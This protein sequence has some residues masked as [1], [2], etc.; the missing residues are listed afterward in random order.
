MKKTRFSGVSQRC[1]K[2]CTA[3]PCRKHAFSVYVDLRPASTQYTKGGFRTVSEAKEHRDEIVR[4]HRAGTLPRNL[5]LT[6]AEYLTSWLDA[7]A[8]QGRKPSTLRGYRQ[9]V[10]IHLTPAIGHL[11]LSELRVF[12]LD[13]MYAEIMVTRGITPATLTR[14]NATL[15][16]ALSSAVSKNELDTNVAKR[17]EL[18]DDE[19]DDTDNDGELNI[20]AP[21]QF[22]QFL[23]EAKAEL[24]EPLFFVAGMTGLRRGEV[25]ALRWEDVN[26]ED[27]YLIVRK[28]AVQ[29]GNATIV[30][31]PKTKRSRNRRVP[32]GEATVAKLKAHRKA[33]AARRLATGTDWADSGCVFTDEVGA[34][35]H[36]Q[37]VSRTFDRVQSRAGL[38]D[39]RFHDLRHF[40]ASVMI[41][42]GIQLEIVSKILGH[43]SVAITSRLYS[44]LLPEA[45]ADAA[46]RIDAFMR[47]AMS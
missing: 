21:K 4:K 3:D 28:N 13:T 30:G 24:L 38:P 16:S 43:S 41:S 31:T 44:H 36:P 34:M 29:V 6:V 2:T 12:H 39:T 27:G 33:Q 7:K 42:A 26:I 15:K 14:I 1:P 9:H 10:D 35:L 11:K 18:P 19:T 22:G 47:Q 20:L 32:L 37:R 5:K 17:V 45:A 25:V 8:F 46:S 40:A 23:T